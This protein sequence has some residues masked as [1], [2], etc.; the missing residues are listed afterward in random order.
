MNSIQNHGVMQMNVAMLFVVLI[1]SGNAWPATLGLMIRPEHEWQ[2]LAPSSE[3]A[4]N[5]KTRCLPLVNFAR[6]LY[7]SIGTCKITY[8]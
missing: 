5:C 2:C 4:R 3:P 7:N 1:M 6:V 8:Q